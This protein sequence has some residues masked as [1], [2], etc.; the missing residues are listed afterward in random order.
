MN[1]R[2]SVAARVLS[3]LC[4]LGVSAAGQ[5]G[6]FAVDRWIG[7]ISPHFTA[8]SNG[9]KDQ[10]RKLLA[11]MERF[12]AAF[13]A[14]HSIDDSQL[15]PVRVV[16]LRDDRSFDPFRP[17]VNGKPVAAGGYFQRG[18][19]YSM[20]AI[21]A[22]LGAA[23]VYHEYFHFLTAEAERHWP[24]WLREGL[25][26]FYATFR[27]DGDSATLGSPL[28]AYLELL[29]R[30]EL[31]PM[32]RLVK[33]QD[34]GKEFNDVK[35]TQHFYAQS[36]ALVHYLVM[37]ENMARRVQ[38]ARF[39]KLLAQGEKDDQAFV[40]AFGGPPESFA[41]RLR[42]YVRKSFFNTMRVRVPAHPED[43]IS[44]FPIREGE[45][46]VHLGNLLMRQG[47]GDE[48]RKHY[49]K[50][51]EDSPDLRAARIGLGLTD[52]CE[53]RFEEA[54]ELLEPYFKEGSADFFLSYHYAVAL[55]ELSHAFD[56]E[57]GPLKTEDFERIAEPLRRSIRLR[58]NFPHAHY[59]LAALHLAAEVNLDEGIRLVRESLKEEPENDSFMDV[60]ADLQLASGDWDAAEETLVR[61]TEGHDDRIAQTASD[62]LRRLGLLRAA[63]KRLADLGVHLELSGPP[64]RSTPGLGG[65]SEL[66]SKCLPPISDPD[67][68]VLARGRLLRLDCGERDVFVVDVAGDQTRFIAADP[69]A[70]AAF[71]CPFELD[72]PSCGELDYPATLY[73]PPEIEIDPES[74]AIKILA[75]KLAAPR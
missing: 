48:A 37:S 31:L 1:S 75:I 3:L 25:A 61:L 34:T 21:K 42:D 70:T 40:E 8:I 11:E 23:G 16:L 73:L 54:R 29:T 51:L 63:K 20:I 30:G 71:R 60:L 67:R 52:L 6:A 59:L 28:P 5:P 50:A 35:A 68:T 32:E 10:S 66:E 65:Q 17:V 58:P 56:W 62:R 47:R 55:S 53:M 12:R 38:L 4:A 13:L 46:S 41:L 57:R 19:D 2:K 49:Q 15:P 44:I 64:P 74:G 72:R 33:I 27:S 7:L 9:E 36:W 22:E 45:A 26:T 18:Y 43:E 14:I 24:A 69:A 39:V